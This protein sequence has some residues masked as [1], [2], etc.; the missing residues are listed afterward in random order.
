MLYNRIIKV[1]IA[2]DAKKEFDKLNKLVGT[3]IKNGITNSDHQTLL[4]SIKQKINLL[5]EN[6][7]YGINIKKNIIPKKYIS[8][9]DVNNLWKINLSSVWRM[10][11]TIKG[12][13]V[14]IICLILD[15]MNHKSYD[16]RFGYKRK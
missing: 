11:Y 13:Q 6:P 1:I 7:Q 10:I 9:Y 12:N 16:K 14:E 15:L 4:N 5:K 2:G 3:E 8:D